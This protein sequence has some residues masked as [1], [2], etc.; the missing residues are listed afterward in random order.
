MESI[1]Q[2]N[3]IR[4]EFFTLIELLVVIAIIAIL[5]SMLLP[6]L[7]K[8]RDRAK[9]IAC[10]SN[11]K[12]MALGVT[13]YAG[14]YDGYAPY[15][16]S[17]FIGSS[18]PYNFF[19]LW[20]RWNW[21]SSSTTPTIY[22]LSNMI[23]ETKYLPYQVFQCPAAPGQ[24]G[25]LTN[26]GMNLK[27]YYKKGAGKYA[28]STYLLRPTQLGETETH[29]SSVE[30]YNYVKALHTAGQTGKVG[31]RIGKYTKQPI[32]ADMTLNS[33]STF[34]HS[35]G[36]NVA[37]EDGS[38]IWRNKFPA[39]AINYYASYPLAYGDA[40]FKFFIDMT[41]GDGFMGYPVN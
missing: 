28:T 36:I 8:A 5:A 20:A 2:A 15:S 34:T 29:L 37:Y 30:R 1:M 39:F 17:L 35:G 12:Q 23:I 26:Y 13:V 6:A 9:N 3:R 7:G 21:L 40:K 18:T 10:T 24:Q 16:R 27:N 4:N 11:L 38:V 41:R 19:N 32:A 31:Y 14:D 22:S 25:A 33:K